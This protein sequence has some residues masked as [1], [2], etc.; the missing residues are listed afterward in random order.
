MRSV[1]LAAA[2]FLSGCTHA[3]V[4]HGATGRAARDINARAAYQRAT[5]TL[6]DGRRLETSGFHIRL[7]SATWSTPRPVS[8][9]APL[10][11]VAEIRFFSRGEGGMEGLGLGLLGGALV[12]ATLGYV[13]RD[14]DPS[15]NCCFYLPPRE[16]VVLLAGFF[17]LVGGLAGF[18]VGA[19]KGSTVV[20]RVRLPR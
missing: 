2:L 20:Y 12:G 6:L 4:I 9:G 18:P 15:D 7:D 8:M 1:F 13:Y 10:S 14:E 19:V 16:G 17:G 11:N 5:V 3:Y